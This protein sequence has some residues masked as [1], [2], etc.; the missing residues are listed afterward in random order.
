VVANALIPV[1]LPF[2]DRSFLFGL[3]LLIIFGPTIVAIYLL[4]ELVYTAFRL[5]AKDRAK[6]AS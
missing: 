3:D 5:G 1:L 4:I 2:S 6:V